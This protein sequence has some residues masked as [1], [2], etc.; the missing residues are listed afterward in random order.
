MKENYDKNNI[1]NKIIVGDD[2]V[3]SFLDKYSDLELAARYCK[4]NFAIF[5]QL[6]K[7]N[8]ENINL[9]DKKLKRYGKILK[10]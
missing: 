2:C 6:L 5:E 1:R 10:K 3:K 7:E 4:N 9:N 8:S